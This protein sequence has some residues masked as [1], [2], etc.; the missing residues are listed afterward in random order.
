M[1]ELPSVSAAANF[2]PSAEEAMEPHCSAG[3][4]VA[5]VQ[6]APESAEV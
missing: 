3:A 4:L 1:F 2:D 6:V 5:C